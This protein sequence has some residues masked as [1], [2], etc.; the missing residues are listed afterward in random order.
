MTEKAGTFSCRN[1]R[2]TYGIMVMTANDKPACECQKCG[3]IEITTP[4]GPFAHREKPMQNSRDYFQ[5]NRNLFKWWSDDVIVRR[6]EVDAKAAEL[7]RMIEKYKELNAGWSKPQIHPRIRLP[8]TFMPGEIVECME[9]YKGVCYAGYHYM[10]KSHDPGC[11]LVQII[12]LRTMEL[13]NSPGI[14][15]SRFKA[16]TP[17]Q[18]KTLTIVGTR[19]GW[20]WITDYQRKI[21]R[22]I[23]PPK[24]PEK[25]KTQH[26][27]LPATALR[28]WPNHPSAA[29]IL[30]NEWID[31]DVS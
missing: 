25:P 30:L 14:S 6:P 19:Q 11:G 8:Y 17:D 16:V 9:T 26:K 28:T 21:P 23:E 31:P 15:E 3:Y 7:T 12:N 2:G 13:V 27:P 20:K 4:A 10:V 22:A 24:K 5:D 29:P 1:C 18:F